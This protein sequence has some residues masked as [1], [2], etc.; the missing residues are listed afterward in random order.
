MNDEQTFEI[1]IIENGPTHIKGKFSFKDSAGNLSAEHN[2]LFF[3]R[4]GRSKNKPFCDGSHK[5]QWQTPE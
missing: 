2:E 4:C 3:C 5:N 1:H